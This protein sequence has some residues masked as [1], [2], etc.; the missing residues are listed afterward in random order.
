[1]HPGDCLIYK[2]PI[3]LFLCGSDKETDEADVSQERTNLRHRINPPAVGDTYLD[4][5]KLQKGANHTH[6]GSTG[7]EAAGDERSLLTTFAVHLGILRLM[8]WLRLSTL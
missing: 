7:D 1:M 3:F 2:K 8:R 5:A 6:Q 4:A